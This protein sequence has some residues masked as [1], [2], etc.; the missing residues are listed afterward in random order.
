MA[1]RGNAD[2]HIDIA[3][4]LLNGLETMSDSQQELNVAE[5]QANA[6]V[7]IAKTL[8]EIYRILNREVSEE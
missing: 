6:T 8:E 7:A 3:E 1:N 4:Q 2:F 5:A